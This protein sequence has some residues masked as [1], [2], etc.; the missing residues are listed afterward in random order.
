VKLPLVPMVEND[1][2]P[3]GW[4]GCGVATLT[5]MLPPVMAAS[6]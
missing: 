5:E 3:S 6:R 2:D 1:D 4:L